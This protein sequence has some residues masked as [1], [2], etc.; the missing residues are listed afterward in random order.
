MRGSGGLLIMIRT[1]A[2]A[3]LCLAAF[4]GMSEAADDAGLSGTVT[5]PTGGV[6][7]GAHVALFNRV[8]LVEERTTG[9]RGEFAFDM[10]IANTDR[11]II[12][13]SGFATQTI[14]G[15]LPA[16][17]NVLV[18]IAPMQDSV[19]V[20][21]STIDATASEQASTV[22]VITSDEIRER[23]EEQASELL[24]I[25]PGVAIAQSGG[26][27]GVTSAFVRGGDSSY[28]LVTIDGAPVNS[29]AYGGS[30]D[31]SQIPT[32]FLDRIEV[33]QGAQSAVY[34]SYANSGVVNF[35]TRSSENS[36]TAVDVI[37]DG[38][39]HGERRFGVSG[40]GA[41]DGFGLAGSL[42]RIDIDSD[43]NVA[44][45]AWMNENVL[46]HLN[47]NWGRQSFSA[48]G[49]FDANAVG[50]PGPYGSDPAGLYPGIDTVSRDKN[51]VSDYSFHYQAD[52]TS[53]I[54]EELL[55]G[56]FL[57]NDFYASPYGNSFNK[58]IRGEAEE[59]T[60]ISVS[61]NWTMSAGFTWTREEV[62]NTFITDSGNTAYPLR[63]DEQ[64]IYWENRL[65][66]GRLYVQA[67]VRG[68]IFETPPI[69]GE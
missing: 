39:S 49:D 51:N 18:E 17:L 13:A 15:P 6:V 40:T 44:N 35:V 10:P 56:F 69:P 52:L 64:G 29:F 11:V 8:G 16:S 62:R 33:V 65:Q 4:H 14:A 66:F 45:S 34:G 54:R 53:R 37:A 28:A 55:G 30:F 19:R 63:R 31:F 42:S 27:G 41:V 59:R 47:R 23:N 26:R 46:L 38:G 3:A 9:K 2:A 1:I 43:G 24:R 25:L 60:V 20:A 12:T 22:N 67:G 57:S 58:D 61:K 50:V 21:G 36:G 48:T 7:A 68:D 32:D 5:D